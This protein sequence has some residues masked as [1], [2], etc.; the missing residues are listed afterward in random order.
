MANKPKKQ[1]SP[2]VDKAE[3][4]PSK[5][6]S[7]VP[8]MKKGDNSAMLSP[9]QTLP[10]PQKKTKK[11]PAPKY[12]LVRR[13]GFQEDTHSEKS[14]YRNK[15]VM[16]KK[17]NS[18][19]YNDKTMPEYISKIEDVIKEKYINASFE[20]ELRDD[21]ILKVLLPESD[22]TE[23]LGFQLYILYA[24]IENEWGRPMGLVVLPDY[25]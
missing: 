19:S 4:T 18:Y 1:K 25:Y 16:D 12:V 24:Q 5:K 3:K 21:V 17:E 11:T 14:N 8:D 9:G 22:F 15:K 10:K 23:D 2:K 13:D 6:Q 20:I 7:I